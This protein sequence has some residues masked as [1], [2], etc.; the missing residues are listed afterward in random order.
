MLIGYKRGQGSI[1]LRAKLLDSSVTTGAGLTGLDNTS[2]GLIIGTI[3]DNEATTTRYRADSSE[4][5]TISTLGTFAAP[6]AGKCRFKEV[7]ATNHPGVCEIQLA[8]ARYAVISAKSLLVSLSGATNLAETDVVIPL[9]DLDPY[10]SVRA[11]LS[12]LPNAAADAAGG[13]PISDAG[14]LD[15]DNRMLSAGAVTAL[16]N[17]AGQIIAGTVDTASF[18]PTTSQFEADDITEST[19]DHYVGRAIIFTSGSLAGQATSITDYEL[20]GSNGKFTVATMTEA[21]GNNDTFVIV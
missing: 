15:L 6:S 12:A 8:D 2:S 4:I 19:D 18:T 10:D 7:D 16:N 17:S 3:A 21:P 13:L 20:S 14:G 5:E 11:G 1:I 9:R